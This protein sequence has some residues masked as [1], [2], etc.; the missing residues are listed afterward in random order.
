MAKA[1]VIK[2]KFD[3]DKVK[4]QTRQNFTVASQTESAVI[5]E[6]EKKMSGHKIVLIKELVWK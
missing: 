3:T 6:L 2:V 5:S 1:F 4:S